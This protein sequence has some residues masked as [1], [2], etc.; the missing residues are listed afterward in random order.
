MDRVEI[1]E[2]ARRLGEEAEAVCRHYLSNGRRQG[3]YWLV[4][5]VNNSAGSSLY[6]R[7]TGPGSGKGRRGK[8]TDAA[9]GEHGDLLDLIRLNRRHAD[10]RETLDE[11]RD[12]LRLPRPAVSNREPRRETGVDADRDAVGAA[13]RLFRMGRPLAGTPVA[14]YLAGRGLG[15]ALGSA[16]L[17]YHPRCYHRL[18]DGTTVQHPALLA[19]VTDLGGAVTGVARTWLTRD[20]SGKADVADPRRALGHLL[21]HGVRFAGA[22]PGVLVAGE[23]L[24]T[25]L[26]VRRTLPAIPAVAALSANHLA[27]LLF[28]S[29]LRRLYVARDAD[30]E[31]LRAYETLRG[32]AEAAGVPEVRELVPLADDFNADLMRLGPRGLAL[33]LAPQLTEADA[34]THLRV[35][36]DAA[37]VAA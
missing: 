19:A 22:V 34:I 1:S 23:G 36:G 10:W 3:R 17:R 13:Q 26:S 28:P 12:F 6:V 18:K 7:L 35:E 4:G 5:D 24:E 14:A 16:A 20:G 21:G 15:H 29:G 32:R 25:V 11:V 37:D 33:H 9:N 2:L 8:W 30:P 31:G 27:A